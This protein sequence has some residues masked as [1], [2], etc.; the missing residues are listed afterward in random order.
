[1]E[2]IER[3]SQHNRLSRAWQRVR[4]GQGRIA[5]VSGEAGIGKTSLIEHFLNDEGQSATVLR[6]ACDALFSPQPLG[7]FLEIAPQIGSN[8]PRLIQSGADRLSFATDLYAHLQNSPSPVILMLE[9]LHWADE[10]TLDVVKYLGR[11]IQHTRALFLGTYRDDEIKRQHPLW[12]LLGDFPATLT[13]RIELPP[14]SADAVQT[15][16]RRSGRAIADLHAITAGNPFFVTEVIAAEGAGLP[17][18]VRDAV[19]ARTARLSEAAASIVEVAALVPGSVE[20]QL[21]DAVLHPD[22]AAIDECVERGILHPAG[23]GLAF[24]HELARQ[25]VEDSLPIGKVRALHTRILTAFEAMHLD[26]GILTRLVHHAVRAGHEEAI[27]RYAL[28]A[29]E[30]ASALGAHREAAALYRATLTGVHHLPPE[31]RADLLEHLSVESYLID[32]VADAIDA[33][34]GSLQIW[35]Q[36]ERPERIGDG[37]RWLSRLQWA[38]SRGHQAAALADEAIAILQRLPPGEALAMAMSNKSQLHMLAWEEEQAIEWGNRA[39]QLAE[40]LGA[41]EILVHA[42]TNVGSTWLLIDYEGGMA[43]IQQAMKLA[44]QHQMHEHVSRCYTNLSTSAVMFRQYAWSERWFEEGLEYTRALDLDFYSVYLLGFQARLFFETG[45]WSEAEAA[46]IEALRLTPLTTVTPIP[47]L[48]ALGHLKVRRGEPGA[49]ELLEQARALALPTGELQRIGPLAAARAEAAW[50]IGDQEA[51]RA[52]AAVGYE[53]ALNRSFPLELGL[54]AYWMWQG[55]ERNLPIDRMATPFVMMVQGDW[56][57]AAEEWERIGCP[58]ERALALMAG[59]AAAQMAALEAFEKLGAWPAAEKVRREL[60]E[61][62][63]RGVPRRPEAARSK[64][65][66]DLTARELEVLRLIAQGL[67]NPDIAER[68][69]VSTG[70]IKAHTSSIYSKLAVTN[71]VQALDKARAMKLV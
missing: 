51:I 17:P 63:V 57:S 56:R 60:L 32:R 38:A 67:S 43:T 19:L 4:E 21:I 7:A 36:L 69:I 9:D 53:L 26:P 37:L 34:E 48:L 25:S 29:A 35:R 28:P 39:I 2:L 44:H 50:V 62:G 20:L 55:G 65:P 54:M 12:F 3:E 30:Q 27:L 22:P 40:T 14:L 23:T 13:D 49:A 31:Q 11:R 59:D 61:R 16:A 10:A 71:R 15:L 45:R 5:L 64:N 41:V 52:E 68:L 33:R 47:A 6:G 1:M 58:F 8:L 24:R 46:A 70:T 18:S 42:L 66:A